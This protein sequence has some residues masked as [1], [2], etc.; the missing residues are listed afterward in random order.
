MNMNMNNI[1]TVKIIQGSRGDEFYNFISEFLKKSKI[2]QKTINELLT[3]EVMLMF[4]TAL[5]HKSASDDNYEYYELIGDSLVNTCIVWYINNK[6]P[7]LRKPEYVKI[8]ARLKINL[9]SKKSFY[10]FAEK[11][12]LWKFVTASEDVKNTKMKKTMEDV[13]EA[14]FGV[15]CI[16]LDRKNKGYNGCYN[17]LASIMDDINISLEYEDLYDS[18]T[19]LK[20]TF[21]L[22]KDLGP[23]VYSN[24]RIDEFQ[25]VTISMGHNRIT[26]GKGKSTLKI[27]AEQKAAYN[28]LNLLKHKYKIQKPIPDV[29][30]KLKIIKK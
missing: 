30:N 22:Y 6:F 26:L 21:D 24:Q 12:D 11:L 18:K 25:N 9:I 28:A 17:I 3:P 2:Q 16:V 1:D 19:I 29:F 4:S 7:F 20:E 13:F 14:L 5:T 23:L 10:Q 27:D 8:V 15:T